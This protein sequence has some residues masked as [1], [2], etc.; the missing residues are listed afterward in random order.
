MTRG[1]RQR[2]RDNDDE[3]GDTKKANNGDDQGDDNGEP[4]RGSQGVSNDEHPPANTTTC[5]PL[6]CARGGI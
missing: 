5:P 2:Q 6:A 4:G 1:R 3:V